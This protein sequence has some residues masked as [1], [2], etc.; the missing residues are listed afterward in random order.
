MRVAVLLSSRALSDAQRWQMASSLYD[1]IRSLIEGSV[2]LF[3][4]QAVCAVFTGWWGCWA[5][6]GATTLVTMVRLS[7]WHGFVQ[8]R[9]GEAR[10][11]RSPDAWALR[12][13]IGICAIAALWAATVISVTFRFHDAE[14]LMFVFLIQCGWL[15]GA[16]VRNAASPA[17]ILGQTL[18]TVV[19]ASIC[20]LFGTSSLV[21][22]LA[23]AWCIFMVLSIKI[24][25]FYSAQ[26]L[27][28][29]ETEQRLKAANEQLMTLSCTDGL[30]GL[31]NRRAFDDRLAAEWAFSKRQGIDIAVVLVDVD[32][33]K[34]YNDHYG[35]LAGDDC[36]RA[37]A[38]QLSGVVLRGSD[39]P[40][41]Y[42]G[43]EFV[44]LL[45]GNGE[46]GAAEVAHRLCRAVYDANLPHQA[47]ALGRVT[48]SVGVASMAPGVEDVPAMLMTRADQALYKAKLDGRNQVCVAA[49]ALHGGANMDTA[50]RTTLPAQIA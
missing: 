49:P 14:L 41:R 37:I 43:E 3:T 29:M 9:R 28:L 20:A 23:P 31:A 22:L 27:S 26:L 38:G 1:Q 7:H 46:K 19:P 17:S 33:F 16:G 40:A 8:A 12:Y 39:L 18:I 34:R 10:V 21:H 2:A 13:C 30:T 48:I 47:S 24:S 44:V 36:L 45:P 4:T 6:A 35:H 11:L 50:Q 15:V 25:R 5:L 32:H 42:G